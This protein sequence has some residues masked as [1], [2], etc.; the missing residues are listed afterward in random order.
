MK[1]CIHTPI[2]IAAGV[3]W[4]SSSSPVFAAAK[5]KE[6][7]A[8]K[9]SIPS[10][11][12]KKKP[13]WIVEAT[14]W[15]RT[16][17]STPKP[18]AKLWEKHKRKFLMRVERSEET[19]V[20]LKVHLPASLYLVGKD[21]R[22]K[23]WPYPV[24]TTA[25]DL[26]TYTTTTTIHCEKRPKSLSEEPEREWVK[27]L[28]VTYPR[29]RPLAKATYALPFTRQHGELSEHHFE[30]RDAKGKDRHKT[31]PD[32][33]VVTLLRPGYQF[34]FA[35]STKGVVNASKL[36]MNWHARKLQPP[37]QVVQTW[38]KGR[39]WWSVCSVYGKA[40]PQ[41][42]HQALSVQ[43][44]VS[45]ELSGKAAL[46]FIGKKAADSWRKSRLPSSSDPTVAPRAN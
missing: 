31:P 11:S 36:H 7:P 30:V 26:R 1:K 22:Q 25:I 6:A 13:W 10:Y 34:L 35:E 16:K 32:T 17:V 39:P 24:L 3:L 21:S 37:L 42:K 2:A 28:V 38:E 46:P 27:G 29:F 19:Q 41:A 15:L 8:E 18:E 12:T 33:L 23:F 43:R 14:T 40:K 45:W 4:L 9:R 44:V 20:A 5:H